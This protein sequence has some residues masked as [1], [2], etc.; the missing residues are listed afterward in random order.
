MTTSDLHAAT[1]ASSKLG[2]VTI[3]AALVAL[4]F[5][6]PFASGPSVNAWQQL[7]A[8][9]CAALLLSQAPA[10]PQQRVLG[11]LAVIGL[12]ILLGQGSVSPPGIYAVAAVSMVAATA[13]AGAALARAPLS[14]QGALA[15]GV[16]IAGFLSAILG[17]L[18]YYGF[19]ASLAPWV[20]APALGQAYGNLRQ[21][22]QF[23]T[24]ISMAL[25]AALWLYASGGRHVRGA[26]IPAAALLVLALAASTSRTGLVQLLLIS[27]SSAWL[28][29]R[30][31]VPAPGREGP[32]SARLPPPWALLALIPAYFAAAWL[33]P[34]LAAS[35]VEGM[36]HRLREGA[37]ADHSRIALWSN[38][39]ELIARHPWA[40]WGWGELAFAHYSASYRGLRFTEILD[41]AHS[42]PLHLAVELG[43]PAA[44]LICGGFGW[45]V[46]TARPWRETDPARLMAW[47][48]LGAILLHSLLEYPLWY[49][50]FQ[51]VF[52]LCLGFLW[53]SS[54][55]K[56][57]GVPEDGPLFMRSL[58]LIL[59]LMASVGYAAW[60]YTRI[61][62]LY[63][64]R[65]D[66]LPAW[67]DDTLAKAQGS[68]LF[69]NQVQFAELALTQVRQD[70]AA[71]VHA[72]AQRLLHFSPEPR[73][74]IKLIDSAMLL[75][76]DA[77]A[78]AQAE[79]FR[80][81]FPR[82][83]ARWLAEHPVDDE[84]PSE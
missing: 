75:G 69:A 51:L 65:E 77:E 33:L 4:P 49:G 61:S 24:L 44:V 15:W 31:R 23:A 53:P 50:P 81:A 8:F 39:L 21:R 13:C 25:V 43:I 38:V 5:L 28:A 59:A 57:A 6:F 46:W 83:Y 26:A 20:N 58:A 72:M 27:G 9:A 19:A 84:L 17:L 11:L 66:R 56:A 29:W 60:D 82:E 35:G 78:F 80:I 62:Q 32:A 34:L 73:V 71:E 74:V 63:L 54:P 48:L 41:N 47:G 55:E 7:A 79:R 10:M 14:Q 70:N 12:S 64:G 42:L 22:N 68:W 1:P 16:F 18:Q 30:E 36:M 45:L 52:G 76:R 67:R 3:P 37:P 2:A 40:G